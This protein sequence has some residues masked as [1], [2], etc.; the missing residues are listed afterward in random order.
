LRCTRWPVAR[1][2]T[3]RCLE[4]RTAIERW[5][6]DGLRLTKI[7]KLRVR[8]DVE[9]AYPT[10]H[11]F[12]YPT[13]EETTARAIEECEAAWEFFGGVFNII[14]PDTPRPSSSRPTRSHHA[15]LPRFSSTRRRAT[16][17]STP[18]ACDM[19]A[20]KSASNGPSPAS[21]TIALPGKC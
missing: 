11:R 17:T 6:G 8:Q 7:P 20:T 1:G 14:I 21:A 9:I 4:Q 10:L 3:A 12:V 5:L 19:P 15:S 13:F 16:F 2:A 18:R